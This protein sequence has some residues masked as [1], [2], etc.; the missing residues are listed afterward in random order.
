MPGDKGDLFKDKEPPYNKALR[1]SY[2]N[3]RI[4]AASKQSSFKGKSNIKI[5]T[6]CKGKDK[7]LPTT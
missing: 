2:P 4:L 6:T 1:S 5:S 3:K 7:A